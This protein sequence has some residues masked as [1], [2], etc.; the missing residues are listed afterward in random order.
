MEYH[1]INIENSNNNY[2]KLLICNN[3]KQILENN[4]IESLR[5]KSNE[6]SET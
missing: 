3:K 2:N 1:G 4:Y 5:S 6:I